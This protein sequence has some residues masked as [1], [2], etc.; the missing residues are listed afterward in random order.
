V[1]REAGGVAK[2][3]GLSW[4]SFFWASPASN[5]KDCL[6]SEGGVGGPELSTEEGLPWP[7]SS[8][9]LF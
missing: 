5:T 3:D 4:D 6:L 2:G 7:G 1:S 9:V 8:R